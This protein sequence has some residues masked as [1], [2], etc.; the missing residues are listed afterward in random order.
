MFVL[1]KSSQTDQNSSEIQQIPLL[2]FHWCH[3]KNSNIIIATLLRERGSFTLQ[4]M[5][6]LS[7][8]LWLLLSQRAVT[9]ST[10]SMDGT[11]TREL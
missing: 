9:V 4:Q 5:L 1:A 8:V 11:G 7:P 2:L 3:F 10:K 6:L